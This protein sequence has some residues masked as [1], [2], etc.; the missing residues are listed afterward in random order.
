MFY[1]FSGVAIGQHTDEYV[2]GW[3]IKCLFFSGVGIVTVISMYISTRELD[4]VKVLLAKA[5]TVVVGL[6]V[7]VV[8]LHESIRQLI[9]FAAAGRKL[10]FNSKILDVYL[11]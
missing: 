9:L 6:V 5:V 10:I 4:L 8:N 1:L 7:V 3:I 2:N 11:N